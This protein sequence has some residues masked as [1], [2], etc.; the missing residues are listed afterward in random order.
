MTGDEFQAWFERTWSDREAAIW[1]RYGASHPVGSPPGHVSAFP[2]RLRLD[3]PGA[4][5]HTFP[6]AVAAEPTRVSRVTW[7]YAIHGLTQPRAPDEPAL[8]QWEF[9]VETTSAASWAPLLLELLLAE[10]IEGAEFDVG[11]RVAY[12]VHRRD[13]RLLPYLGTTDQ[14]G[15]IE[16]CG[17]TR[18]LLLWPHLRPWGRIPC[19]TGTTGLLVATALTEDEFDLLDDVGRCGHHLQ[20]LLCERGVGQV[21]DVDRASVLAEP[22]GKRA[23]DRIR[24]LPPEEAHGEIVA[25]FTTEPDGRAWRF[26]D[27]P[28]TAVFSTRSVSDGDAPVLLVTHG[29]D[30]SWSFMPGHAVDAAQATVVSLREVVRRDDSLVDLARLPRGWCAVRTREEAPWRWS[31]QDRA[32]S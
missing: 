13:G 23:W 12:F 2:Q 30:G 10:V 15:G 11:H 20:L 26:E 1:E 24:R 31:R 19:D 21:T 4:C 7:T 18:W 14:H 27:R 8:W 3:C 9:A 17:P 22:D 16:P 32:G 5:A 28:G 25:R 29:S 6:P